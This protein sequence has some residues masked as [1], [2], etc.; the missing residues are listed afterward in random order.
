MLDSEV[1]PKMI[2]SN[3][4]RISTTLAVEL[5]LPADIIEQALKKALEQNEEQKEDNTLDNS[6][7]SSPT[8]IPN[9][10]QDSELVGE[11]SRSNHDFHPSLDNDSEIHKTQIESSSQS[12]K[13]NRKGII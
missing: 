7:P 13:K 3:R 10:I 2:G 11:L 12:F 9:N 4:N 6:S 8:N 1:R 5:G